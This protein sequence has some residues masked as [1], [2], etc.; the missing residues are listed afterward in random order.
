[1]TEHPTQ[2][3]Q[4]EDPAMVLASMRH[5]ILTLGG[6]IEIFND[7]VGSTAVSVWMPLRR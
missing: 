3:K 1:M 7:E 6:K 4:S 2:K 5:R